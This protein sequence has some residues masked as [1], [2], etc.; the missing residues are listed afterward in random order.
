MAIAI[1]SGLVV[2]VLLVLMLM[3][4]IYAALNAHLVRPDF[5]TA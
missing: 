4:A 5:D 2:A 1:I 3:P